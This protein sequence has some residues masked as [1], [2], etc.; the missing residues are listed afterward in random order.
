MEPRFCVRLCRVRQA[1]YIAWRELVQLLASGE[2]NALPVKRNSHLP[3]TAMPGPSQLNC[4][5][6]HGIHIHFQP[7]NFCMRHEG[8][9][10]VNDKIGD[11]GRLHAAD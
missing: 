5:F 7:Q 2:R 4:G 3:G 1:K 11:Y 10:P 8:L 6:D 9:D